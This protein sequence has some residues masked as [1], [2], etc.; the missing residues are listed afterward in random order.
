MGHAPDEVKEIADD[1]AGT[2]DEDGAATEI[3]RWF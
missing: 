2:V 3:S 1:V